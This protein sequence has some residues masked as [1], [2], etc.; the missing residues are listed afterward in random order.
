MS[1][2]LELPH[3]RVSFWLTPHHIPLGLMEEA[4]CQQNQAVQVWRQACWGEPGPHGCP[5]PT[6]APW[7]LP[8]TG[9]RDWQFRE[10]SPILH[11]P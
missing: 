6:E 4:C 11:K 7:P 1:W 3:S 5:E 2:P 8:V 10:H 9:A